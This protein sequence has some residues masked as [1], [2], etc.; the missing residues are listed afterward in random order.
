MFSPSLLCTALAECCQPVAPGHSPLFGHLLYFKSFFDKF[1][2]NA[3]YQ[4]ALGDIARKHFKADGCFYIDMWP[5]SGI[6]FVV[7]S[8]HVANQIHTNPHMSMQR[9]QLLPRWFNPIAGGP[10]MFD[11]RERDWK[12]WRAVFSGAFSAQNVASLVPGMVDQTLIY[13][14]TLKRLAE[15]KKNVL[16]GLDY[17]AF[18]I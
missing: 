14:A 15:G 8:P 13:V 5:V 18:H 2:P 11:M 1:P 7:V 17:L 16:S 10:N 12:P 6:L 4:N 9:P 3:H